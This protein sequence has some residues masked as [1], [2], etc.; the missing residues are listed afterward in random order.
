[1]QEGFTGKLLKEEVNMIKKEMRRS[2]STLLA[3]ALLALQLVTPAVAAETTEA[4]AVEAEAELEGAAAETTE[5]AEAENVEAEVQQITED[6]AQTQSI[7]AKMDGGYS[8]SL[9]KGYFYQY[10]KGSYIRPEASIV[11]SGNTIVTTFKANTNSNYTDYKKSVSQ[12]GGWYIYYKGNYCASDSSDYN[13]GTFGTGAVVAYNLDK[14][15]VISET[16]KILKSKQLKLG[17]TKVYGVDKRDASTKSALS[18]DSAALFYY[19]KETL[20]YYPLREGIDY[21]KSVAQTGKRGLVTFTPASGSVWD[22]TKKKRYAMT[23]KKKKAFSDP[24]YFTVSLNY[25]KNNVKYQ[26]HDYEEIDYT[27][28]KINNEIEVIVTDAK[29]NKLTS[30]SDYKVKFTN[31]KAVGIATIKITP[32][33]SYKAEYKGTILKYFRIMP[34]QMTPRY[35]NYMNASTTKQKTNPYLQQFS[36][37]FSSTKGYHSS[38]AFSNGTNNSYTYTYTGK[39]VVPTKTKLD[40]DG[41][42]FSVSKTNSKI[43]QYVLNGRNKR[44]KDYD[45][46]YPTKT[47]TCYVFGKG[48]YG[49]YAGSYRYT[50]K[51]S[52]S[53][54]DDD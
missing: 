42:L 40:Y 38:Y 43:V 35:E 37:G 45:N 21:K 31:N 22:G 52:G 17:K 9:N 11:L 28:S 41:S 6:D 39:I 33:G 44:R 15:I 54:S 27:G 10:D 24:S 23:S 36:L 4:V 47:P 1:M 19:D 13:Y 5:A 8:I 2:V 26:M 50:I 53:D 12:G 48:T 29:G 3:A 32:A 14:Q 20:H 7:D 49:G 34:Y 16:F 46:N 30:G 25:T 51:A 18:Q